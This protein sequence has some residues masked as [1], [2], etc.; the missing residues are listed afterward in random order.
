M[1][2]PNRIIVPKVAEKYPLTQE[3][4]ANVQKKNPSVIIQKTNNQIPKLPNHLSDPD[5]IKYLNETILLGVRTENFMQVFPSPGKIEENIGIKGVLGFHC[6]IGCQFC[7][8]Q[9]SGQGVPWN[10]VYVNVE[11]F[12]EEARK[13]EI[14]H[15]ICLTL[16]SAVS[17]YKKRPLSKV[18][19]GYEYICN[20]KIRPKVLGKRE[21]IDSHIKGINFLTENL[22]DFFELMDLET[23]SQDF[24]QVKKN[25]PQYF[26]KNINIKL[27]LDISEYSDIPS[28]EIYT[29]HIDK[30]LGWMENDKNLRI[31]FRTKSPYT[32]TIL[33]HKNL[34]RLHI[35]LDFN[36]DYIIRK[37]QGSS[38]SLN[39]RIQ[40]AKKLIKAGINLKIVV[41]PIIKY[42]GFEQD[43]INLINRLEKEVGLQNFNSICLGTVRYKGH[44]I[45]F[46]KKSYPNSE[47]ISQKQ[48]LCEPKDGDKRHRYDFYERV[49][50][51][52]KL[53]STLPTNLRDRVRLGA[54]HPDVW[55]KLKLDRKKIHKNTVYQHK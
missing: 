33:K 19:K 1:Y 38:Y 51:Y 32:K 50:I 41:E 9:I 17:F 42:K 22:S 7:Y 55:D 16:W 2:T 13:E 37:Y 36:T 45:E 26:A 3:I 49:D 14:V 4:I 34:D 27:W 5:K 8:L 46:I 6:P 12:R 39:K 29:G 25:I 15:K 11:T 40:A 44:M 30:I 47:L 18:P 10:R 35:S 24:E 31:K 28:M 43:Y 20:K 53:I 54:E 23:D 52:S 21:P 48:G